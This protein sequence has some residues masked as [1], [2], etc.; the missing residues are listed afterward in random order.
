LIFGIATIVISDFHL[1]V[2][3]NK[4]F[5]NIAY[6]FLSGVLVIASCQKVDNNKIPPIIFMNGPNP[7]Y[8]ILGVDF[9]DPGIEAVDDKGVVSTEVTISPPF[10]KDSVGEYIVL[11]TV[12]DADSNF[13][14]AERLL[15]VRP[16][17]A[18]DYTGN[19]SVYDTLKPLSDVLKYDAVLTVK[20]NDSTEIEIAN[21]L[22]FGNHF[23]ALFMPDSL[24]NI[25]LSCSQNDTLIDGT[26]TTFSDK[27]GFR[28]DYLVQYSNGL[29]EYHRATF[30]RNRN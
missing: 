9:S 20:N 4:H 24:G 5:I 7:Q 15:I 21:F 3:M 14:T 10:N 22:N 30:K 29:D 23:K 17:T 27:T 26:G 16:L 2:N 12:A 28:I 8:Q 13:A 18:A 1:T 6:F 25:N 19:Y 11:Y